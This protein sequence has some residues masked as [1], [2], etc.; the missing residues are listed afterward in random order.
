MALRR[1]TIQ[2]PNFFS[3]FVNA[4][5]DLA[6]LQVA[7]FI[8]IDRKWDVQALAICFNADM[9][10]VIMQIPIPLHPWPDQL[11][12]FHTSSKVS[13]SDI[14]TVISAHNSI[15]HDAQNFQCI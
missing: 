4:E 6:S 7:D 5:I 13:V 11:T 15:N 12:W 3:L 10:S 9:M 1:R 8:T 2:N 14:A